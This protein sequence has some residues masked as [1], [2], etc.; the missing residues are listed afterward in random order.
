VSDGPGRTADQA[1]HL[2]EIERVAQVLARPLDWGA[3]PF[4]HRCGQH[5][6]GSALVSFNVVAHGRVLVKP[7]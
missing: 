6:P 2:F 1:G 5:C 7:D 4:G 3:L